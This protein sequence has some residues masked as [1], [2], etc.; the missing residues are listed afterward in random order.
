MKK[1]TIFGMAILKDHIRSSLLEHKHG[2]SRAS[3]M[4]MAV[5]VHQCIGRPDRLVY[6]IGLGLQK[7]KV[8]LLRNS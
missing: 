1:K 4:Q 3:Q 2:E 5:M 6:G 7:A 8:I